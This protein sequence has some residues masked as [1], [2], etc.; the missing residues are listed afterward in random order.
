MNTAPFDAALLASALVIAA[1]LLIAATGELVSQKAG[2][3]NVGLEGM[4]LTGAFVAFFAASRSGSLG[5][6]FAFG[7][8]AAL[9]VGIVMAALSIEGHA[10][11]IVVGIA[12]NLLAVGATSFLNDELFSGGS[13]EPLQT[14]SNLEIPVLSGL[15]S[16]GAA[17]FTQ[18][19][20][21][22]FSAALMV[23]V[24]WAMYRTRWGIVLRS[25]GEN[26]AA[27]DAA[28]INVKS[29]RWVGTLFAAGC[30]G[31]AGA[32]LSI[33]DVGV[34]RDEMTAGRG[35]LALAAVLFGRWNP[36]G[37]TIAVALFAFAD[38]LQ[39][40]LQ[41]FPHVPTSVWWVIAFAVT[42]LLAVTVRRRQSHQRSAPL[43][44]KG[45]WVGLACAAG[46]LA[47]AFLSPQVTVSSPVWLASPFALAIVALA[48]AGGRGSGIPAALTHPFERE[49]K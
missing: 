33:G 47:I 37:T 35:F 44:T 5:F 32:Y 2:V 34:F 22:Y 21:V 16:W 27:A 11:Q 19:I 1:P 7:I 29:V 15:G 9:A 17:L 31:L 20:V 28:G 36:L 12:I 4:I 30:A 40:R 25:V 8:L 26:P 49:A 14:L 3:L 23:A 38:A 43:L 39:L 10:D 42:V 18:D 41:G 24:A 6:G 13:S 45:I 48:L 46:T